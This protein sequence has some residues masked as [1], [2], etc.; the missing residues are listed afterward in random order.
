M[1]DHVVAGAVQSLAHR[2]FL[3]A[4]THYPAN[5]DIGFWFRFRVRL[6]TPCLSLRPHPALV[7]GGARPGD[8]TAAPLSAR[9]PGHSGSRRDV[10]AQRAPLYSK[11]PGPLLATSGAFVAERAQD[12]GASPGP[13]RDGQQSQ[14]PRASRTPRPSGVEIAFQGVQSPAPGALA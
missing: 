12:G 9:L 10:R 2:P 14:G 1:V 3:G 4:D 8:W 11:M 5:P 7:G 13:G 6:S